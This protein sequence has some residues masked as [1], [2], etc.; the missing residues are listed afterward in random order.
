MFGKEH[1]LGLYKQF[2]LGRY[3]PTGLQRK[4]EA[5]CYLCFSATAFAD[6]ERSSGYTGELEN[7]VGR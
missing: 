2:Y 6:L 7:L 5:R 1:T 4:L 3:L